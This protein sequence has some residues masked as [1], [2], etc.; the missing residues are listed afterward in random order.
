MS[1]WGKNKVVILVRLHF[2][3]IC[4]TKNEYFLRN[5]RYTIFQKNKARNRIKSLRNVKEAKDLTRLPIEE[6]M[7][8]RATLYQDKSQKQ[9]N[10]FHSKIRKIIIR[11]LSK[12]R[13][14]DAVYRDIGAIEIPLHEVVSHVGMKDYEMNL[15]DPEKK[16][17]AILRVSV[18]WAYYDQIVKE[19]QSPELKTKWFGLCKP[20]PTEVPTDP[21]V[22]SEFFQRLR[23]QF[24]ADN[25]PED[26][27]LAGIPANASVYGN[28]DQSY[29]DLLLRSNPH[30]LPSNQTQLQSAESFFGDLNVTRIDSIPEEE[31]EDQRFDDNSEKKAK[32][33]DHHLELHQRYYQYQAGVL[34]SEKSANNRITKLHEQSPAVPVT[35][36]SSTNGSEAGSQNSTGRKSK[37]G[38]APVLNWADP[39]YQSPP[40][41]GQSPVGYY[42]YERRALP[43]IPSPSPPHSA[44][45]LSPLTSSQFH[46]AIT[47]TEEDGEMGATSQAKRR[48]N[49]EIAKKVNQN[50]TSH[51]I[52]YGEQSHHHYHNSISL[53]SESKVLFL[54]SDD[55][56]NEG[57]DTLEA[58]DFSNSSSGPGQARGD[59]T[60]AETSNPQ[61]I[62]V[63]RGL[64]PSHAAL[65]T[66][67][68]VTDS[69]YSV[70]SKTSLVQRVLSQHKKYHPEDPNLSFRLSSSSNT[71]LSESNRS[72]LVNQRNPY[73][74]ENTPSPLGTGIPLE[75]NLENGT[76]ISE[77]SSSVSPAPVEPVQQID[78]SSLAPH[79]RAS[80]N[81]HY[82]AIYQKGKRAMD[83]FH[84][85]RQQFLHQQENLLHDYDRDRSEMS[86][87]STLLGEAIHVPAPNQV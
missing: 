21:K 59:H 81:L 16:A 75:Q 56:S 34:P 80:T 6:T 65:P 38:Y 55:E 42:D 74:H 10:H 76:I 28:L 72:S 52:K 61:Y 46:T 26:E 11:Q 50:M 48:K 53:K 22:S 79:H 78:S 71:H 47:D 43:A 41:T 23:L 73:S 29:S 67:E 51:S 13:N 86:H 82:S 24:N 54:G 85:Q 40:S 27:D 15:R 83:Q 19:G 9:T 44:K 1:H 31:E 17:E 84:Q 18:E 64:D 66:E 63:R 70:N 62:P 12:L 2:L 45:S 39:G 68:V 58:D 7:L 77:L 8:L 57:R 87:T 36:N 32:T 69:R 33:T 20:D 60:T 3:D 49:R 37:R 14:G 5:S 25:Q 4:F 30:R 35:S